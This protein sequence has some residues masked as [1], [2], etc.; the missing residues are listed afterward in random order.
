MHKTFI[1]AIL[2]LSTIIAS[3]QVYASAGIQDVA[4]EFTACLEFD[5]SGEGYT[6]WTYG[7]FTCSAVKVT[8]LDTNPS[9]YETE[10]LIYKYPHPPNHTEYEDIVVDEGNNTGWVSCGGTQSNVYV[11]IIAVYN[12]GWNDYTSSGRIEILT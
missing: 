12:G 3:T 5:G 2:I 6:Y 10:V 11:R 7:P 4:R 9:G 8:I 1:S